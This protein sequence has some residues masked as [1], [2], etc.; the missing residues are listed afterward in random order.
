MVD[1]FLG[2]A[3]I[4]DKKGIQTGSDILN[5]LMTFTLDV[6]LLYHKLMTLIFYFFFYQ[7]DDVYQSFIL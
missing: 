6:P 4:T 1:S 3:N 5:T 2:E 7:N